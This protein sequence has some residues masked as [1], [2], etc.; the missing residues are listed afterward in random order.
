MYAPFAR[1]ALAS[2]VLV[3]SLDVI[4]A[5]PVTLSDTVV[6]ASGFEQKIPRR[7]PASA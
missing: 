3:F 1:T 5:D 4:A 2:A 6:S 7:Q